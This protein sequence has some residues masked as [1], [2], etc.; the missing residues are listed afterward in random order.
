MPEPNERSRALVTGASDREAARQPSIR[1][2]FAMHAARIGVNTWLPQAWQGHS[3]INMT[4]R[5]VHHVEEHHRP[6]PGH[7]R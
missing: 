7:P 4:L 2:T 3:T 1:H 5:Y 6:H